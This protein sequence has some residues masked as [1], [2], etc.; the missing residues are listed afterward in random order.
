MIFSWVSFLGLLCACPVL[1]QAAKALLPTQE[2]YDKWATLSNGEL[3]PSGIWTTYTLSYVQGKDSL[4]LKHARTGKGFVLPGHNSGKFVG[5]GHFYSLSSTGAF[6]MYDLITGVKWEEENISAI[7]VLSGE[8]YLMLTTNKKGGISCVLLRSLDGVLIQKIENI[9]SVTLSPNK[10]AVAFCQKSD[11][12][13][14]AGLVLVD[15]LRDLQIM[16]KADQGL[17]ANLT[18]NRKSNTVAFTLKPD[19]KTPPKNLTLFDVKSKKKAVLESTALDRFNR[20]IDAFYVNHLVVSDDGKHILFTTTANQT[21]EKPAKDIP[22]IWNAHDTRLESARSGIATNRHYWFVWQPVTD[23]IIELDARF[24]SIDMLSANKYGLGYEEQGY[25]L[26]FRTDNYRDIYLI[27]FTNGKSELLVKNQ[28]D[29][30]NLFVPGPNGNH[31]AY[32]NDGLGYIIHVATGTT[33]RIDKIKEFAALK[34]QL[35]FVAWEENE[36][37][38]LLSDGLSVWRVHPNGTQVKRISPELP[39]VNFR[40]DTRSKLVSFKN[41]LL[42]RANTPDHQQ[43]GYFVTNQ[44]GQTRC[45]VYRDKRISEMKLSSGGKAF[46]YLEEDSDMP[47]SLVLSDTHSKTVIVQSNPQFARYKWSKSETIEFHGNHGKLKGVLCFP[48]D[49]DPARSYPMIVN[50]YEQ[51]S[52]RRRAFV[53]PSLRNPAAFNTTYYTSRDYFVLF[54]DIDYIIGEPGFSATTCVVNATAS[55]LEKFPVD[56]DRVGLMGHSFGGYETNF[57]ITQTRLFAAAVSGA[58]VSDLA[59]CYLTENAAG[60]NTNFWRFEENQMRMGKSFF[61][62]TQGYFDNSPITHAAKVKTPLLLYVGQNDFQVGVSQT[63]ELHL[64]MR[65]LRKESVMLIYPGESHVFGHAAGQMDVTVKAG[66]W[67]DF[68]LKGGLKPAWTNPH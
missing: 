42:L 66:Q 1:G 31:I 20:K 13:V 14:I 5:E 43:S 37:A 8:G 36:K 45:L 68:Y 6:V 49:Y 46:S 63:M 34:D 41:P 26:S 18:W 25:K 52:H 4:F 22:H 23:K 60:H 9:A 57:I 10:N 32:F 24:R 33:A 28:S 50:V 2:E 51:Q 44:D 62:D 11:E 67:F 16:A 53:N 59:N 40:L 58:G 21:S 48:F 12:K 27:D 56:R 35:R 19:E 30:L 47:P 38:V 29:G 3:S 54:P 61:E 55:V 64:A 15:K 39:G 7:E 17:F 65:R